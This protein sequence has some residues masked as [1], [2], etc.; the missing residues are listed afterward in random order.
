[1]H[2]HIKGF[3]ALSQCF[4]KTQPVFI[5]FKYGR[6]CHPSTS[7]VIPGIGIFNSLGPNHVPTITSSFLSFKLSIW[8]VTL[9]F[10]TRFFNE[11]SGYSAGRAI[12]FNQ[13]QRR[14]VEIVSERALGL[15]ATVTDSNPGLPLTFHQLS[16][17][18]LASLRWVSLIIH[19]LAFARK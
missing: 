17:Q 5:I 14:P 9:F 13:A 11:V 19:F 15:G 6:S 3:H 12:L 16:S 4:E 10:N 7:H 18:Q 1:M 2:F 8:G